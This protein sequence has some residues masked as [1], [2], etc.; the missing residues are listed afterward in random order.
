[1]D[2]GYA[3]I[4]EEGAERRANRKLRRLLPL[5]RA[6]R[7]DGTVFFPHKPGVRN[8]GSGAGG[9]AA[10][11]EAVRQGNLDQYLAEVR[12]SVDSR[13]AAQLFHHPGDGPR[14]PRPGDRRAV[15]AHTHSARAV[16]PHGSR[17]PL[18][19]AGQCRTR[20][21]ARRWLQG[22]GQ[23]RQQRRGDR[24]PDGSDL[25]VHKL[26]YFS[27]NLSDERLRENKPFLAFLGRPEGHDDLLQGH[28]LHAARSG[29]FD[30]SGAGAGRERNDPAG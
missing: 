27:V 6:G 23:D 28:V 2:S 15:S 26:F 13:D 10:H 20:H 11:T 9:H 12:D 17:P 7:P 5:Q 16:A 18:R 22:A 30:H 29:V 8:G 4:S 19:A 25:S 14:V 3:R 24:L 21:R 1:M